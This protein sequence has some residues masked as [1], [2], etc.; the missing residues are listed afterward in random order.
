MHK[1]MKRYDGLKPILTAIRH[2]I[3]IVIQRLIIEG[4][5]RPH[6]IDKS[7]LDPAPFDP[8]TESV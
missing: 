1:V 6:L 3:D 8:K 5:G 4:R 2:Y 7:W